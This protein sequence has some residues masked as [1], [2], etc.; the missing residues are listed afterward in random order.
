MKANSR[1]KIRQSTIEVG[2]YSKGLS[3]ELTTDTSKKDIIFCDGEVFS[4]GRG[5]LMGASI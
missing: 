1:K 2:G 5:L 3:S 4:L